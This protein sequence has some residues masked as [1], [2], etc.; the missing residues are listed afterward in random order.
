M[1][2]LS[3]IRYKKG[4][5]FHKFV[6][7]FQKLVRRTRANFN[8]ALQLQWLLNAL[9]QKMS[10]AVRKEKPRD[11]EEAIRTIQLFINA[12]ITSKRVYETDSD[13][14][15]DS[16]SDSQDSSEESSSSDSEPRKKKSSKARSKKKNAKLKE[17]KKKKRSQ[18]STLEQ[19]IKELTQQLEKSK[20]DE[21]K[22]DADLWCSKCY[23]S[24]HHKDVCPKDKPIPVRQ[25]SE[26]VREEG[27]VEYI[28]GDAADCVSGI[29]TVG[30]RDLRSKTANFFSSLRTNEGSAF[31]T[32][33]KDPSVPPKPGVTRFAACYNCGEPSH[34]A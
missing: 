33:V 10:F 16:D 17:K 25:I 19:R 22:D 12:D 9:P 27:R 11:M 20:V 28:M 4:T 30:A 34:F 3:N 29:S 2:K 5:S 21:A 6:Q 7:R 14:S 23:K 13:S 15:A 24:G 26:S 32:I 18:S 8:D 1:K 31:P